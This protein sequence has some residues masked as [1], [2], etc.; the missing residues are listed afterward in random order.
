MRLR[1]ITLTSIAAFSLAAAAMAG[2]PSPVTELA[3]TGEI[4]GDDGRFDYAAV[5][6]AAHRLYVARGDGVMSIDLGTG[7]VT[8]TLIPGNTVH[9]VVVL[10][11]GRLLSTNGGTDTATLSDA[12]GRPIGPAIPTGKKP[13]AAV[14]DAKSGLVFVMNGN[15]GDVTPIDPK[16]GGPAERIAVGGKLEFA[17]A[18]GLGHV[19]V[20]VED[21]AE[22]AVIDTAARKVAARYPLA[23]C[24]EPSGLSLDPGKHVLLAVCQNQKAVAVNAEDGTVVASLEIGKGPDAAIFDAQRQTF[25]VP[26]GRDGVLVAIGYRDGKL[27]VTRRIPTAAGARTGALDPETGRLYLPTADVSPGERKPVAGTFRILVVDGRQP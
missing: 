12:Q 11:D 26:C 13:D 22:I 8:S 7:K 27:A 24:T 18:D 21:K 6:P 2:V 4:H 17:V 19:F 10:S 14:F 1:E 9:G 15:S 3:V 23:G 16:T 25:F 5:D 20:N